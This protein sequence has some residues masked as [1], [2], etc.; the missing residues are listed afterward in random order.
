M[1]LRGGT[2]GLVASCEQIRSVLGVWER[3][4]YLPD[5]ECACEKSV[6]LEATNQMLGPPG[7][8][9]VVFWP[10][11]INRHTEGVAWEGALGSTETGKEVLVG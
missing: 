9:N 8:P 10:L 3:I 4:R 7:G 2:P 5:V 6:Y 1:C 11:E